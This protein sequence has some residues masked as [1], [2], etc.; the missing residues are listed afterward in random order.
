VDAAGI[1][2]DQFKQALDKDAQLVNKLAD[3]KPLLS[4]PIW[5][6]F[7]AT[8]AFLYLWWL[9]IL[10]FDLAF[11][12]HRYI[13][14]SVCHTRLCEWRYVHAPPAGG[15]P[16]RTGCPHHPAAAREQR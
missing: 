7:L 9:S 12:W 3:V 15:R 10:I 8:A 2:P 4:A 1:D 6:V 11:T 14:Q 5:P 13:R 16:R